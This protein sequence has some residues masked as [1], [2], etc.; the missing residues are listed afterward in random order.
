MVLFQ[1]FHTSATATLHCLNLDLRPKIATIVRFYIF[2]CG[3]KSTKIVVVVL[4]AGHANLRLPWLEFRIPGWENEY[5]SPGPPSTPKIQIPR[6]RVPRFQNF[7]PPVPIPRGN[8]GNFITKIEWFF[9]CSFPQSKFHSIN[10]I[11]FNHFIWGKTSKF[12]D[13]TI[14]LQLGF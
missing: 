7:E 5:P 13:T 8:G 6:P 9:N 1:I 12:C 3:L 2:W 4:R 10:F 14:F 11:S